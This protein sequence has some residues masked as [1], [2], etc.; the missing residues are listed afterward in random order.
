MGGLFSIFY[1]NVLTVA[2]ALQ[3]DFCSL[4]SIVVKWCF[5]YRIRISQSI[6]YVETG[7]PEIGD[8]LGLQNNG[9][10]EFFV[11]EGRFH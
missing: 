6:T 10:F 11:R 4:D 3:I 5:R 7:C 1:R 8:R 2:L 9:I